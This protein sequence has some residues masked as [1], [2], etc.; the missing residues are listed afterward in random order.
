MGVD[1]R[2][3]EAKRCLRRGYEKEESRVS[4]TVVESESSKLYDWTYLKISEM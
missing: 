4:E 1:Y 3:Q 2:L